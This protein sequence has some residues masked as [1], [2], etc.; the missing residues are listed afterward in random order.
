MCLRQPPVHP[1]TAAV[2]CGLARAGAD[3]QHVDAALLP[4]DR[5]VQAVQ[6]VQV[7]G[8][9]LDAGDVAADL[10]HG[11]VQGVLAPAGDE[12][13]RSLV[14]EQL[15][16][17]Q[18]HAGGAVL[19]GDRG[20]QAHGL[21]AL[22][23]QGRTRRRVPAPVRPLRSVWRVRPH[24]PHAPQTA[25]RRLRHP[26]STPHPGTQATTRRPSPPGSPTPPARPAPPTLNSSA[27]SSRCSSTAPRPAPGSSTQTPSPAA[28]IAAVLIDNAIPATAGD[29]ERPEEV[30]G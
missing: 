23:Q 6:V 11:L 1:A 13:V 20:V 26:P 17:G 30:A 24:R 21:P 25:P 27:S 8:V 2:R 29:D 14:D 19:R 10:L 9:A 22:H 3:P 7:G 18:R 4:L 15:R 5:V 16:A 12:D 28:A